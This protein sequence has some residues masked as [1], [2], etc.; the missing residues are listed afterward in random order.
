MRDLDPAQVKALVV[1]S[2]P[3]GSVPGLVE[4]RVVPPYSSVDP[5]KDFRPKTEDT[6]HAKSTK[7]AD[8]APVSGRRGRPR[9]VAD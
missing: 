5:G 8:R 3:G 9:A 2:R 6:T 4:I 1:R 7:S